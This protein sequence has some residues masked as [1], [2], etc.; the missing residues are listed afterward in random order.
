MSTQS[1]DPMARAHSEV[2]DAIG[3]WT[4]LPNWY[5]D[6]VIPYLR[7]GET[8]VLIYACRKTLGWGK[9]EDRIS[10]SQFKNGSGSDGDKGTGLGRNAIIAALDLLHEIGVVVQMAP[11][12]VKNQGALYRVELDYSKIHVEK[13]LSRDDD[14]RQAKRDQ[15][16]KARSSR[17]LTVTFTVDETGF[18]EDLVC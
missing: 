10:L 14:E 17:R 1:N 13:L 12:D 6:H 7:H 16:A 11:N 3:N 15:T 9:L 18:E 4:A 5:V 8:K 2:L